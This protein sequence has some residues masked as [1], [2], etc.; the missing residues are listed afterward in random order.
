MRTDAGVWA[1]SS[2][3]AVNRAN[4]SPLV[5]RR[6]SASGLLDSASDAAVV[7]QVQHVASRRFGHVDCEQAGLAGG[8]GEKAGEQGQP[9]EHEGHHIVVN[10]RVTVKATS[11]SQVCNPTSP[12]RMPAKNETSTGAGRSRGQASCSA[13]AASSRPSNASTSRSLAATKLDAFS[14]GAMAF[15][16][17]QMAGAASKSAWPVV[18]VVHPISPRCRDG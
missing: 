6:F 11:M 4:A 13:T 1:G 14:L 18:S 8:L 15:Q 12:R 2:R 16:L 17:S 3:P 5:V 10:G 9:V 7:T